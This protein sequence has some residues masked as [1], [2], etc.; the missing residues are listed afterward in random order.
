MSSEENNPVI[1]AINNRYSCR[2][3]EQKQIS[4]NILKKII[5][6][7]NQAPF[8]ADKGFQP[9]RF[10]VVE[11]LDFKQKLI[12]TTFP[13]WKKSMDN[14]KEIMPEIYNAAMKVYDEMPEPKDLVYYSAPAIVF[15]IGS[16]KKMFTHTRVI[17]IF[18]N[19]TP[20]RAKSLVSFNLLLI[21]SL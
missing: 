3:F 18:R 12:Q 11:N 1:D 8:V 6:A 13:I 20:I 7:G 2:D 15:V 10:V 14:I 21:C 9:W 4:K 5:D 19:I 16:K 17:K